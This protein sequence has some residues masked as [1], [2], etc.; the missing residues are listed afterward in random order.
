MVATER[1]FGVV[2]GDDVLAQFRPDRFQ[3]EPKVAED[4]IVAQDGVAALPEVPARQP[5]QAGSHHSTQG[6]THGT[7]F[8]ALMLTRAT[9]TLLVTSVLKGPR[10][11]SVPQ[12]SG[13]GSRISAR[14]SGALA[15][16]SSAETSSGWACDSTSASTRA[17]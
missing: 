2:V 11:S 1:P 17:L 8:H 4:R 13:T 9:D 15:R 7:S 6:S 16:S 3:D 10:R 14:A 12:V 5:G